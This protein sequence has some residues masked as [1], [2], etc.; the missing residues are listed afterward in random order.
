M[1]SADKPYRSAG[2]PPPAGRAAAAPPAEDRTAA[3]PR[4]QRGSGGATV[5]GRTAAPTS[6]VTSRA[7]RPTGAGAPGT[8]LARLT[9]RRVD[10][11]SVMKLSFLVSVALGIVVVI[12]AI[13]LWQTLDGMGVF[14]AVAEPIIQATRGENSSGVNI[15]DYIGLERVVTLTAVLAGV[16]VV[17]ITA[18]ATLGAFL[19][20]VCTSLVGGLAVTLSEEA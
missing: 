2:G 20:N 14:D 1:S 9:V 15:L 3:T 18:F 17:L 5:A 13:V 7:P 19:Y 12:A 11:W 10:P 4:V 8:R 6:T 16:N